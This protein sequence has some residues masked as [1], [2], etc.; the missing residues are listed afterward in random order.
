VFDPRDAGAA[1]DPRR[2][3]AAS[4]P[5]RAG[6]ASDPRRAGAASDPRRAGAASDPRRAGAASDAHPDG[7]L[8]GHGW[9]AAVGAAVA[10]L[11]APYLFPGG[12][13]ARDAAPWKLMQDE[14]TVLYDAARMAGGEVMYRDWF[15]FMGPVFYGVYAALFRVTGPS[16]T[17]ARAL[18]VMTTAAAAMLLALLVARFAGRVAGAGAAAVYALAFVPF[19]PFAYPQWLAAAWTLGAL[20]VLTAARAGPRHEWAGG[21]LLGLACATIQSVGVPALV[22]AA[23]AAAAPGLAARDAR[24][25]LLRPARVLAGA[26][27][28]LAIF[29]A[30][31]AARGALGAL[32]FDLFVWPFRHYGHGQGDLPYAAYTD[33]WT[34]AHRALAAPWRW[35]G[36]LSLQVTR[37]A[38]VAAVPAAALAAVEALRRVWRGDADTRFATA[39][40]AG[41]ACVAPLLL[42]FTRQDLT[43]VAFLGAFGLCAVAAVCAP[44]GAPSR[45]TRIAAAVLFGLAGVAAAASYGSKLALSWAK[46]RG[47]G[48]WD[49]EVMKLPDSAWLAAAAPPGARVVIGADYAGWRYLTLRPAAVAHTLLPQNALDY[50]AD[51]QW[52]RLAAEI[53]ARRPAAMLLTGAQWTRLCAARP[54]LAALYRTI[55]GAR[56]VLAGPAPPAPP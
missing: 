46:S 51:A 34:K 16:V 18:S 50:L 9:L 55:G 21:V 26:V 25:A 22:A 20:A 53:A 38:P 7:W 33:A 32:A 49:A 12:P 40:G 24:A 11:H 15:E 29:A 35:G 10:L 42:R 1:S 23:G 3:G 14:G 41:V 19:W 17:A 39:A 31:Y 13:A 47:L 28:V 8:R 44:R 5:R 6:A 4:D 43:H 56:F 48:D 27:V 52:Q 30:Y 2:A 37:L 54:D 45:A 36:V